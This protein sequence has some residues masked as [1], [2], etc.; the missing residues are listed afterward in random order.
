VNKYF[1]ENKIEAGHGQRSLRGGAVTLTARAVNAVLQ[2]GSVLFLA[3]L[4]MPE[5]YGLV[6]M[7]TAITGFA[8][9]LVDLGTRDAIVQRPKIT[10]GEISA[11]FW[12]TFGMGCGFALIVG[13]CSPLI[14]WFYHEPRLKM[15]TIV[16]GATFITGALSCQHYALL[17]RAM[18]F[19]ELGVIEVIANLMSVVL[20]V[21]AAYH[22]FH[23]WALVI[24]PIA[25]N[26]F[27]AIGVW[28]RCNWLPRK[29]VMNKA[30]KDM[31]VFGLHTAG[32]SFMDFV[33]GS[34][35]R[36]AIGYRSGPTTLGYYQNAV[37]VYSNMLDVM[38][39]PLHSVAVSSL[40]KVRENLKELRRLWSKALSTLAF[41]SMP[42][43]GIVAITSQDLIVL[44]LGS[45]WSRA[46]FLLSILAL[47][48]IPHTVERTMG[49]L[50]VAAG[51]TDRW[52]RYGV[53]AAIGQ[54]IALF[55]GLPWGTTG[56]AV[57]YVIYKFIIF[58]PAIAY[59]G[60]PL[61]I[62]AKDVVKVVWS[63]TTGALIA[64]ACGFVLRYTLLTHFPGIARIAVLIVA[65]LAV[66]FI[67]VV[68]WFRRRMPVRVVLEL[69]RGY[70]PVRFAKLVPIPSFLYVPGFEHL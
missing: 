7:V 10:E 64:A 68:G 16:S 32:F 20:A 33:G 28:V 36:V 66:Y 59:A 55:A 65:Y 50:H 26:L 5:D 9:M 13:C 69:A 11:L 54:V 41:Y 53:A 57:A 23:Y 29:P 15:I 49:W 42:I 30:V 4:L 21:T 61:G 27:T 35:D 46:G 39:Y 6:G 38:V 3:R 1:E 45:K 62:G 58:V 44:L 43:F 24:R 12:I 31:V 25:M 19:N 34:C 18:K 40:S 22:G 56:V 14:A 8:A 17:R 51:R 63:Q 60:K 48:G 47:R 2:I 67:T 52:M 70:L 37:F